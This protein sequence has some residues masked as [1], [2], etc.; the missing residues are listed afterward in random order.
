[1]NTGNTLGVLLALLVV[2]PALAQGVNRTSDDL[3]AHNGNVPSAA[4]SKQEA[5]NHRP[6]GASE[7]RHDALEAGY[8]PQG[9]EFTRGGNVHL[10]ATKGGQVYMV[11]VTPNEKVY[12]ES[13]LQHNQ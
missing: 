2:N 3:T 10:T 6:V 7:A 9:S 1:M 4:T 8:I 5:N 11:V 12:A 13:R